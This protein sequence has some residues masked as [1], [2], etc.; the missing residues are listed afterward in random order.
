MSLTVSRLSPPFG[1]AWKGYMLSLTKFGLN[2]SSAPGTSPSGLYQI[3]LASPPAKD[4]SFLL[5][6]PPGV[7][8][9][10]LQERFWAAGIPCSQLFTQL[11]SCENG[12][13]EASP[14]M[15][16]NE[17][18]AS[19]PAPRPPGKGKKEPSHSTSRT[20]SKSNTASIVGSSDSKKGRSSTSR[21]TSKPTSGSGSRSSAS[22]TLRLS[23][24]SPSSTHKASGSSTS[25]AS[26]R[27]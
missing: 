3:T 13:S 12:A 21:S 20:G 4:I 2:L 15:T 10:Q 18:S 17:P 7:G 11:L 26:K 14:F 5:V 24:A 25:S 16:S 22:R 9:R 19:S 6:L 8:P 23:S 27:K 1:P